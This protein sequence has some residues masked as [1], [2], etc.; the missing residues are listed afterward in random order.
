VR[1]DS[2]I[3]K[4]GYLSSRNRAKRAIESGCVKVNKLIV[5]K[6]SYDV[7][8]EDVVEVEEGLDKPSGYW[9]LKKIQERSRLLKEG[10]IVLDLGSSAGG[11]LLFASEIAAEVHG[12]EFSL[13]FK[14]EL[15]RITAARPNV[16]IEFGDV[17]TT[18]FKLGLFDVIL[19]DLTADPESSLKALE[20]VVPALKKGGRVLQV[21]K[22]PSKVDLGPVIEGLQSL[23]IEV[24]DVIQ[25]EKK[26]V[27]IL[28]R[29]I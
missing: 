19:N 1:L 17:Y 21:V 27:F 23:S 5:R 26:E 18:S 22:L 25:G 20:H 9:K 13:K 7:S 6:P 2:Y 3:V 11:F 12:I 24:L 14:K 10:D 4:K 28:G 15:D 16:S 8:Y 29:K